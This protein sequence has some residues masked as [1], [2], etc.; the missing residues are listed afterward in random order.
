M[1]ILRIQTK[2][3][4][5]ILAVTLV[6]GLA[7]VLIAR[8]VL[9]LKLEQKLEK[10][11]V[12]IAKNIAQASIT[13]LLTEKSFELNM[14][15]MDYKTS[16]EDIEYIY[17][18]NARGDVVAHT[19]KHG[20]PVELRGINKP[21]AERPFSFQHYNSD[22]G[23]IEDIAVP[24][25]KGVAGTLHIGFSERSI[26]QDADEIVRIISW[27]IIA[28][29]AVATIV[30]IGIA[31]AISK[32]VA[33]LS[34]AALAVERGNLDLQVTV[35]S[36][37]E[38]GLRGAAFNDMVAALKRS[39]EDV[40][41][42]EKKLRDITASIGEG[43]L[44]IDEQGRLEFMNPEAERL[45]GWSAQELIGAEL[46][47]MI[48]HRKAE[49]LLLPA[50]EC[51]SLRVLKTGKRAGTDDDVFIRKDGTAFP[52]SYISAP[53]IDEGKVVA[54]VIA[55]HDITQRKQAEQERERLI[56]EHLD[57]LSKIKTLS[58]MLPICSSCKRIRDDAGYWTQI[59]TYLNE[60]SEAEFSHG[61]CPECAEK[62]YPEYYLKKDDPGKS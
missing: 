26:T 62:M 16:E 42:S 43:V 18:L 19:F 40:K 53:V 6:F 22:R 45:L 58:G 10:R 24:L 11:A 59:E 21:E 51:A 14:L 17:I 48:H 47:E 1:R 23:S 30:A 39:E 46:H 13:P 31:R 3:I 35:R 12:S 4:L 33:E 15:A 50:A 36:H 8:T 37:D 57:A 5:G 32:P 25:P 49:G 38:I 56:L 7:T 20:F 29:L 61:M 41:K 52:V 2:M 27:I 60:H 28:G 34:R 44:V 55:F 54:V 9:Q